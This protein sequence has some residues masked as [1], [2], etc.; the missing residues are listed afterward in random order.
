MI[1]LIPFSK[2]ITGITNTYDLM[3]VDIYAAF[4]YNEKDYAVVTSGLVDEGNYTVMGLSNEM[5]SPK[6]TYKL[7]LLP[8]QECTEMCK[9]WMDFI[10]GGDTGDYQHTSNL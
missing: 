1:E 6:Y 7:N 2:Q 4:R 9:V 5:N 10:K 3:T 8:D